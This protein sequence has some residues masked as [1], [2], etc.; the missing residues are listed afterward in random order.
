MHP[1]KENDMKITAE[2]ND[3]KT[4]TINKK[5]PFSEDDLVDKQISPYAVTK[6]AG[7]LFCNSYNKLYEFGYIK[8]RR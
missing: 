2:T 8:R 3:G 7:E 4:Q 5:V 6:R 1:L